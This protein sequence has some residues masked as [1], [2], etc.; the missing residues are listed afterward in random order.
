MRISIL[1]CFSIDT[2]RDRKWKRWRIRSGWSEVSFSPE[3][4]HPFS[5]K[6]TFP[7]SQAAHV[8]HWGAHPSPSMRSL[9]F[10]CVHH[11]RHVCPGTSRRTYVPLMKNPVTMVEGLEIPIRISGVPLRHRRRYR[12]YP[13]RETRNF[14]REILHLLCL[15]YSSYLPVQRRKWGLRYF[16]W[17]SMWRIHDWSP[18]SALSQSSLLLRR[19]YLEWHHPQRISAGSLFTEYR[20]KWIFKSLILIKLR[21]INSWIFYKSLI[22]PF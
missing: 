16:A 18:G 10:P 2:S 9:S 8:T 21:E 14:S 11:T 5:M 22:E 1:Q 7:F 13:V 6:I 20:E 3:N 17:L 19:N 15:L 12:I 4:P